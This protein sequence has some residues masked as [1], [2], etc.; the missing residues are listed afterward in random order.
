MAV[1]VTDDF[2]HKTAVS[3]LAE[4]ET[5]ADGNPPRLP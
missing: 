1:D 5:A 4:E 2:T 3:A